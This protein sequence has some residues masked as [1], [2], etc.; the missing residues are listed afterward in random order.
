MDEGMNFFVII[1]AQEIIRSCSDDIFVC[2]CQYLQHACNIYQNNFYS[3]GSY[4][5][6]H[7]TYQGKHTGTANTNNCFIR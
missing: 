2:K 6:P 3:A 7:P 4:N 1:I 5:Q